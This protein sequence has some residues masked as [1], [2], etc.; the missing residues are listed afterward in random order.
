LCFFLWGGEGRK[1]GPRWPRARGG[2][3][4]VES[5][6]VA[7]LLKCKQCSPAP[8]PRCEYNVEHAQVDVCRRKCRNLHPGAWQVPGGGRAGGE[9]LYIETYDVLRHA[10]CEGIGF[11]ALAIGY[12]ATP[13]TRH[14]TGSWKTTRREKTETGSCGCDP[15]PRHGRRRLDCVARWC[16]AYARGEHNMR[17]E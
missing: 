7:L 11:G 13:H 12:R 3:G 14:A 8:R 16:T 2:G 17:G 4:G 9:T 10:T 15:S 5:A 6:P 1:A